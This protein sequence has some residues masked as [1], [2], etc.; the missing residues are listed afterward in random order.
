MGGGRPPCYAGNFT[1]KTR[2]D[3]LPQ[4]FNVVKGEISLVGPRP[5]RPEFIQQLEKAIPYYHLQHSINP[6]ITGWAQIRYPYGS[7]EADAREKLQ[8]D[9]YEW[10]SYQ[11]LGQFPG[12]F[13]GIAGATLY[14]PRVYKTTPE[15]PLRPLSTD[16][17]H[18]KPG[19]VIQRVPTRVLLGLSAHAQT[20][21]E[22]DHVLSERIIAVRES[23]SLYITRSPH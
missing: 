2:L 23:R 5:E 10:V 21:Y 20:A 1:R 12:T 6:G 19:A 11:A 14:L 18:R 7:S 15:Q 3:E 16:D 13:M 22:F 8:Y 17:R 4:L 9:L